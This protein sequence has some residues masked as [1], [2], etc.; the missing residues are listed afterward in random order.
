MKFRLFPALIASI[1]SSA[2]IV[3]AA[4]ASAAPITYDV[5]FSSDPTALGVFTL[6]T[7]PTALV[8]GGALGNPTVASIFQSFTVTFGGSV[9]FSG[10]I[11]SQL[12]FDAFHKLIGIDASGT[13]GNETLLIGKTTFSGAFGTVFSTTGTGGTAYELFNAP[14]RSGPNNTITITQVP[15]PVPEPLTVSL[16][17]V[18]LVGAGALY[19]RRRAANT[20]K[21]A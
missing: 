12:D 6:T 13:S 5:T 2:G 16:F 9:T 3:F 1:I 8:Y 11:F 21:A 19:R 18:G 10:D 14:A 15:T 7:T 17:G 4:P 20:A